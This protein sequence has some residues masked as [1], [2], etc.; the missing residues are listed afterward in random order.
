[1]GKTSL[2]GAVFLE[3]VM[4]DNPNLDRKKVRRM[5]TN[6][7]PPFVIVPKGVSYRIAPDM[8][9]AI[10]DLVL[11]VHSLR[12]DGDFGKAAQ[13]RALAI[14][15]DK[16]DVAFLMA[17][18]R[19][20]TLGKGTFEY[21]ENAEITTRRHVGSLTLRRL[22][23]VQGW[24]AKAACRDQDPSLFTEPVPGPSGIKEK[25]AKS[26]CRGCSVWASCLQ[27]TLDTG[28]RG[29]AGGMTQV[30]RKRY[31]AK[32]ASYSAKHQW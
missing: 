29:I 28:E 12:K 13:T 22:P 30:E 4:T 20:Q 27:R 3:E 21:E 17:K 9:P 7:P 1:E 11:R 23:I 10:S 31:A 25:Q 15:R 18:A 2:S 26:I 5:L 6:Y 24:Q 14:V 19:H 8:L 16:S 32:P